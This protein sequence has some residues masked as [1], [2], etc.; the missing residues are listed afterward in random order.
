LTPPDPT[1]LGTGSIGRQKIAM[2][3]GIALLAG[4]VVWFATSPN[5]DGAN[6]IVGT[7]SGDPKLVG[8]GEMGRVTEEIGHTVFWAGQ[9]PGTRIEMSHDEI[10]NAH[11]RYLTGGAVPG[12]P[13][14]TYL[15]IGTY[16]FN[17]ARAATRNLAGEQGLERITVSGGVGFFDP[18]RP[19]SVYLVFTDRPDYQVEVYHPDGDGA[20]EV[21]LSGDI[22]PMP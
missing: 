3:V 16:P 21:A 2:V 15:D 12:D 22:V 1:P 20:L 14:Q 17:G 11:V 7:A 18:E 13:D 10:G 5:R 8:D 4:V 6:P 9:R 19:T